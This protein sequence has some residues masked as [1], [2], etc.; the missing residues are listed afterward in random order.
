MALIDHKIDASGTGSDYSGL[1]VE[2]FIEPFDGEYEGEWRPHAQQIDTLVKTL[3]KTK[4]NGLIDELVTQLAG[5]LGL[6]GGTMTGDIS[7][8]G[9]F[10]TT[11]SGN[12][13]AGLEIGDGASNCLLEQPEAGKLL[14]EA[15][16]LVRIVDRTNSAFRPI[17]ASAFNVGS[18]Y[19][20]KDNINPFA[21]AQ[22]LLDIKTKTFAYKKSYSDDGG[23]V[24]M[25]VI[26]EDLIDLFPDAVTVDAEGLPS[27]VD[28]AK[29]VV[30][31]I[32]MIQQQQKTIEDLTQRI[33]KLEG[34]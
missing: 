17:E 13:M 4:L 33:K 9:K 22:K 31:C 1:D 2:G 30:P 6:T 34:K 21:D 15:A 3:V 8:S 24:H 23:K 14:L 10:A 32:G 27:G 19:R 16:T 28:Y 25:G 29:L 18:S 5:K 12:R 26:A 7:S 11:S 20:W